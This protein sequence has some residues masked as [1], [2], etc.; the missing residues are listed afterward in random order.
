MTKNNNKG[1]SLVELI[2]VIAIMAV[3]VGVLAPAL[4]GNIEKSRE[5]TD[6][7]TLDTVFQAVKTAYGDESGN[8]AATKIT[9]IDTGVKLSEI[10]KTPDNAFATQVKEYLEG[11]DAKGSLKSDV[12]TEEGVD[13]YVQIKDS[14]ITVKVA[15]EAGGDPVSAKKLKNTNDSA[16]EFVFGN[17]STEKTPADPA[18]PSAPK[19]D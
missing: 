13:I 2:V 4:I 16:K 14:Q 1:F 8:K 3:L 12:C 5:S 10:T 18:D 15:T 7:N 9:D 11:K 19:K 17:T 6:L